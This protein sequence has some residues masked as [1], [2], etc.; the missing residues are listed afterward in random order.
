MFCWECYN[1]LDA[2]PLKL[3]KGLKGIVPRMRGHPVA[4]PTV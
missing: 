4:P 1:N 3:R 2:M